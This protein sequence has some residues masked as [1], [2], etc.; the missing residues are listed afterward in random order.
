[1]IRVRLRERP[2]G[3]PEIMSLDQL[4]HGLMCAAEFFCSENRHLRYIDSAEG[5]CED[6]S[7]H[8]INLYGYG[9]RYVLD[10]EDSQWR[11]LYPPRGAFRFHTVVRHDDVFID[12]TA[13]QYRIFKFPYI[14]RFK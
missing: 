12:F 6:I 10:T 14:W 2:A 7:Q 3:D 13:A 1:M 4:E 9:E 8:F 5:E 11:G